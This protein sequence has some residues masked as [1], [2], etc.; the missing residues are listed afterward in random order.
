VGG[1]GALRDAVTDGTTQVRAREKAARTDKKQRGQGS[2]YTVL[3]GSLGRKSETGSREREKE[4][5]KS[6]D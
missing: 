2:T 4:A 6:R 1:W 5:R 3:Q